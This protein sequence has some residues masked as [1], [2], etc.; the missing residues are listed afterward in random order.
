V[1]S[2]SGSTATLTSGRGKRKLIRSV[3]FI[4]AT[5]LRAHAQAREVR[6]RNKR[7]KRHLHLASVAYADGNGGESTGVEEDWHYL[8]YTEMF[9]AK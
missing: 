3:E 5:T 9:G 2:E 1:I 4:L 6:V 8:V 7:H